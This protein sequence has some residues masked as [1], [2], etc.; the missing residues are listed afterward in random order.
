MII[1]PGIRSLSYYLLIVS[2][3]IAIFAAAASVRR[4][5][6]DRLTTWGVLTAPAAQIREGPGTDFEKIEIGHEG[7]EFKILGERES[8]YLIELANNLRGWVEKE[9]VLII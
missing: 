1:R 7:L 4:I 5:K 2:L 3:I 9:A 8:S 6:L